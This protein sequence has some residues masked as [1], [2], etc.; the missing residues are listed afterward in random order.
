M[1]LL[2]ENRDN[3]VRATTVSALRDSSD[4]DK[5]SH[6][7]G[8]I[9]S[10]PLNHREQLSYGGFKTPHGRINYSNVLSHKVARAN[11]I[12]AIRPLWVHSEQGMEMKPFGPCR[13]ISHGDNLGN[14]QMHVCSS[15]SSLNVRDGPNGCYRCDFPR[16]SN[17]N[18]LQEMTTSQVV[19]TQ[20]GKYRKV[21][22]KVLSQSAMTLCPV[23]LQGLGTGYITENSDSYKPDSFLQSN[24]NKD[25]VG[26]QPTQSI[27]YTG[28]SERYRRYIRN[29]NP[30]ILYV[31][32]EHEG[33]WV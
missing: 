29:R 4:V 32:S 17:S 18:L 31:K 16:H 8:M 11:S 3:I 22:K 24:E 12:A 27:P 14:A 30:R 13:N 9:K 28:S 26:Y 5:I 20:G 1:L 10:I 2:S 6:A 21:N 25:N 23:D 33:T 7:Y 15:L 19:A